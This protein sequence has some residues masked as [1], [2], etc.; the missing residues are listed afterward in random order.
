MRVSVYL[1]M[2]VD[3]DDPS[4]V[5]SSPM[6]RANCKQHTHYAYVFLLVRSRRCQM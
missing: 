4:P 1:T 2:S 6:N 5:L 3:T